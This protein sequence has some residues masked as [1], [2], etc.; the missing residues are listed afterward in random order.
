MHW[1]DAVNHLKSSARHRTFHLRSKFVQLVR[2]F[3]H[4]VQEDLTF[5]LDKRRVTATAYHLAS[6]PSQH[7]YYLDCSVDANAH[8]PIYCPRV[9][10]CLHL[11]AERSEVRNFAKIRVQFTGRIK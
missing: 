4:E 6:L 10:R 11:S 8:H 2:G 9:S 5:R 1:L 7:P 3:L